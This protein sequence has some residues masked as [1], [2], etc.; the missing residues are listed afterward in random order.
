MRQRNEMRTTWAFIGVLVGF[1]EVLLGLRGWVAPME[2][3]E[4]TPAGLSAMVSIG[5]IG[6]MEIR[7]KKQLIPLT[8]PLKIG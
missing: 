6:S 3:L 1:F 8:D 5:R 4:N 2:N 7:E